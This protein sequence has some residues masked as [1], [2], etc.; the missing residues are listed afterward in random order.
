MV[1]E[2]YRNQLKSIEKKLK[3]TLKNNVMYDNA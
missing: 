1:V 2:K 3:I